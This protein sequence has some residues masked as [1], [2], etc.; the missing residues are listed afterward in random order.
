MK[1]GSSSE[2]VLGRPPHYLQ[3]RELPQGFLSIGR[4]PL[5]ISPVIGSMKVH[6]V[7]INEGSSLSIITTK[8]LD[9][10]QILKEEIVQSS[11]PFHGVI[12]G[13][14]YAPMGQIMLPVVFG[15][16]ENFRHELGTS[17]VVDFEMVY[18]ALL[19][20]PLLAQF[21]AIPNYTYMMIKLPE[22]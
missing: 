15:E 5:V 9:Q 10:M 11:R 18:N 1:P 12:P 3:C 19:E 8:T 4:L 22:T 2:V 16:G 13:M 6:K 7:L 17:E 20:R 21:R 14:T